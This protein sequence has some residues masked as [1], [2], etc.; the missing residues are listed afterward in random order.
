MCIDSGYIQPL[1]K[2]EQEGGKS[3]IL[4]SVA[5]SLFLSL[6]DSVSSRTE[7]QKE[8]KICL[9]IYIPMRI[10]DSGTEKSIRQIITSAVFVSQRTG[11]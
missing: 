7:A 5:L 11:D 8:K 6:S 4:F 1:V 9:Y 2:N 3:K 10:I